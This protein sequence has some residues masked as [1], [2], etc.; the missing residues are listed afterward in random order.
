MAGSIIH[1]PVC[2]QIC[3]CFSVASLCMAGN[4]VRQLPCQ[5]LLVRYNQWGV[6]V[7]DWGEWKREKPRYSPLSPSAWGDLIAAIYLPLL[8]PLLQGRP[9]RLS[10]WA[11]L[12]LP[13]PLV[14]PAL[15]GSGFLP[16]HL[17]FNFPI[18]HYLG[19]QFFALNFLSLKHLQQ[20]LFSLLDPD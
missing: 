16:C 5:W 13:S 8:I 20:L 19:N 3:S 18:L 1:L 2:C 12:S 10:G 9:G 14:P 7:E 17:L 6:L 11:L 15:D 4:C